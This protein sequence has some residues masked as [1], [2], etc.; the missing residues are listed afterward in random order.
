MIIITYFFNVISISLLY[1]IILYYINLFIYYLN[2]QIPNTTEIVWLRKLDQNILGQFPGLFLFTGNARM[3]RP[4]YNLDLEQI[5]FIGTFEQVYL[6]ISI[7]D[8]EIRPNVS[9]K[10]NFKFEN[11]FNYF[12]LDNYT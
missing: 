9:I 2:I 1:Y 11:K 4:V 5:E 8:D 10:C 3:M 12:Y 6:D 7:S